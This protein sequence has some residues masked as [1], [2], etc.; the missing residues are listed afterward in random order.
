MKG[1]L[2]AF[3]TAIEA[4]VARAPDAPRLDRAAASPPTR[5]ARPVDGTVKVV[6]RL[7]AR[8]ERI[9][10]CVVGEPSSVAAAR[11]HDQERPARHAVRD[12]D[13]STACRVTSR[14]RSS[15]AIRS[16]SSRR[17]SPSSPRS[18]GTTATRT[19]PPTTFQCS[20][21]HAGTGAT[22]VDPGHARA[23]V[24]LALLDREHARVARRAPRGGAAPARPRLRRSRWT[25]SGQA[26]PD[27][28]AAAWSTS[29]RDAI[30]R[31]T[32]RRARAVDA[33]AA[34]PTGASSP[35]SAPRS[36]SSARSTR[37]STSSNERVRD[38]RSRAARRA[39]Y[40]GVLERLL[41]ARRSV[42]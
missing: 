8:G 10:Y 30:A 33:P 40:R 19:F 38:R 12:A 13:A 20:N 16:I 4:F 18:T 2:A 23:G 22:N 14:I 9:D 21:I 28:A 3:V 17:R 32:G 29:R 37:R 36:S 6:E 25:A 27:R 1:S 42:T 31:T 34:P 26:V 11:R 35:T 39:I 41:C 5:K 15:R 24:Q 7:A